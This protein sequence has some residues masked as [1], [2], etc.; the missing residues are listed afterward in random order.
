MT[1]DEYLSEL[2]VR[3]VVVKDAEQYAERQRKKFE[4]LLKKASEEFPGIELDVMMP[5][6]EESHASA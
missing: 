2:H 5:D 3:L 4:K 1:R 6:F